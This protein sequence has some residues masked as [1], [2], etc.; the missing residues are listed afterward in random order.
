M[1]IGRDLNGQ[2]GRQVASDR[3]RQNVGNCLLPA[4]DD[5]AVPINGCGPVGEGGEE[6]DTGLHTGQLHIGVSHHVGDGL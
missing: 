1:S 6:G 4:G 3:G 2:F 5:S